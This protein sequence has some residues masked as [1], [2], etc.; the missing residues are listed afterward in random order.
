MYE[1]VLFLLHVLRRHVLFN[2]INVI[3]QRNT[4]VS[5]DHFFIFVK[6]LPTLLLH[7]HDDDF[8]H[9]LELL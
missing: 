6:L 3:G 2:I 4:F 9:Y 5:I 1:I 7:V 8:F